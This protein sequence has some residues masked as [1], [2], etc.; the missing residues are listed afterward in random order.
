M[1]TIYSYGVKKYPIS[2]GGRIYTL[3][4]R[5][6]M[7]IPLFKYNPIK[8]DYYEQYLNKKNENNIFNFIDNICNKIFFKS[9]N[10]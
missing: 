8:I 10:R 4:P 5:K 9:K 1:T 2:I 7:I 6:D 3:P